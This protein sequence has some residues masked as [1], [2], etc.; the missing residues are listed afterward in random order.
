M[1]LGVSVLG[2][3]VDAAWLKQARAH[4]L[5]PTNDW[6]T[7]VCVTRTEGKVEGAD[8]LLREDGR[9]CRLI[10]EQGGVKPVVM[11]DFGKQGAGGFG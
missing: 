10:F 5:T 7:P 9:S 2:H 3:G 4:V 8:A 6:V 1:T 11:L